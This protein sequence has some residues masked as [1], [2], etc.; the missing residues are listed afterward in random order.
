MNYSIRLLKEEYS[1]V[2]EGYGGLLMVRLMNLCVKSNPVSLLPVVIEHEERTMAI[3]ELADVSVPDEDHLWVIPK[4]DE[5]FVPVA[6][7][8]QETHPEFKMSREVLK[9]NNDEQPYLCFTMPEVNKDR[10][11]ALN[12]AVDAFYE[13]AK[14]NFEESRIKYNQQLAEKL[15]TMS[16]EDADKAKDDFDKTYKTN[17]D[18][19]KTTVDDKKKEIADA[20]QRYLQKKATSDQGSK[21]Q[22]AAAGEDVKSKLQMP[23]AN[24]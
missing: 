2:L 22:A 23:S 6:K 13:D 14:K 9:N 5:F 16:A 12:Q 24:E 8:V 11:D 1:S 19:A 17:V 18:A 4:D 10:Y 21:E 15:P 3:E 7:G 20:Y